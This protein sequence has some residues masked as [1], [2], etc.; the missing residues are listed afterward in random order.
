MEFKI[1]TRCGR[2]LPATAE[3]FYKGNA[4]FGLRSW[5]K[6]CY[7]EWTESDSGRESTRKSSE[8]YRK[9]DKGKLYR[10][11]HRRDNKLTRHM[12]NMIR[13]SLRKNKAGRHWGGFL[14]YTFEELTL[15]LQGTIG[16][17]TRVILLEFWRHFYGG[18]YHIDHIKPRSAF[19]KEKLRYPSSKEFQR[20]WSLNNL[21]LLP[22]AENL[23]KNADWQGYDYMLSV[24]IYGEANE[25]PPQTGQMQA[26]CI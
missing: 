4:K 1:C 19:N 2:E 7:K 21:R 10:K 25:I 17:T 5:C 6:K 26:I 20:C 14:P 9:S 15:H 8:K 11:K 16:L 12:S 13:K 23:E 18:Y 22:A 3:F 24:R